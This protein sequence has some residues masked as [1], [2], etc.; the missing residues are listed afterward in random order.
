MASYWA[1]ETS[2]VSA[3]EGDKVGKV[4]FGSRTLLDA[5]SKPLPIP[6]S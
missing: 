2:V 6:L 5:L 4:F 3:V 1:I